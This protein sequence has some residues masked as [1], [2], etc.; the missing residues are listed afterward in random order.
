MR[1][2]ER[3]CFIGA[4]SMAEAIISGMIANGRTE[5][6]MIDVVI[7]SDRE[8]L[9][10]LQDQYHIHC[11]E[12]QEDAIHKAGTVIL[13]VKPKD[14][15]EALQQW[16]RFI[17][18]HQRVVSV[19]AG[20]STSFIEQHL[21]AGVTVI[22][23][24]PNTSSLIGRSATALCGGLHAEKEDLQ[25][26]QE[27]FNAIGSTVLV[28]EKDM[29]TV[30]GLSGSGPAYIYY[31]VEALEQAGVNE[32]LSRSV[33]RQLTLQTLLG[34]AHM[35]L[36]TGK[37][38]TELRQRVTSPGGTTMVGIETLSNHHFQDA[39]MSAVHF[40]RKRSEELGSAFSPSATK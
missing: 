21:T 18:P 36:E 28:D 27:D 19:I 8:R 6:A 29:D 22:R 30:T 16:G 39:L 35:L 4:G 13:A 26:T 11:P 32:G 10:Y 17:H 7:R 15:L 3:Y 38:P 24:M 34:A 2:S 31:L 40:A 9:L 5:P 25:A 33:A 37:D 20:I 23:T 14:L 12:S 1:H